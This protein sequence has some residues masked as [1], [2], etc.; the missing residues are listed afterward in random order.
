MDQGAGCVNTRLRLSI[1]GVV[2]GVGFRPFI[3]RLAH[4]M[5]LVG[6]VNNSPQGVLIE[7]EGHKSDLHNFINRLKTEK[8][9]LACIQS[10]E[11]HFL[12]PLGYTAFKI[13]ESDTRGR[14]DALILPDVATCADCRREIFDPQNRRYRYPFTNC[15]NCGPRFSIIEAL[16]YD[17]PNTTMKAFPMCEVCQAEYENPLDRRFHAQ[18]NACPV[19]GPHLQLWNAGGEVL[20]THKD[21]LRLAEE[22]IRQGKIVAVKGL[23]GFHLI[24]D[25]RNTCAVQRLRKA[26]ARDEKPFALFYPS[27]EMIAYDCVVSDAEAALLQSPEAPIVLLLRHRNI[28][29]STEVAPGHPYL[30]VMLPYTP[31]HHLL[32]ADLGFP[33]VATSGNLSDEPICTDEREALQRLAGIADLFLVHNRP[34]VRHVDDSIVRLMGGREMIL[35]RARG[36]A[37]LPI[38]VSM[39]NPQSKPSLAVGGHLKNTVALS[40]G[41]QVFLSQHIGDLETAEAFGAFQRVVSDF[42][43]LYDVQPE[44]IAH[45]LHPDYLSTQFARKQPLVQKGVQHHVAHVLACMAENE[46]DPPVLGVSWDGTGYGTD[47]TIWGGEFFVITARKS[48]QGTHLDWERVACIEPFPLPGGETAV[49]EPRRSAIGLLYHYFGDEVFGGW[50]R[51]LPSVQAFSAAELKII[52]SMLKQGLNC[53][54]TSSVGRLF[55]AMASLLDCCQVMN[56]EG[57]AAMLLEFLAFE[58]GVGE[59]WFED[60]QK[61]MQTKN[62]ALSLKP[63]LTYLIQ[64]IRSNTCRAKIAQLFHQM[65]TQIIVDQAQRHGLQKVVISGG[66]FQNKYLTETIIEQLN[67]HDFRVYWHQR[68]PPNDGGISLGQ[69]IAVQ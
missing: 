55:D 16:P 25:A 41:N 40:V 50:G 5:G 9:A 23:G 53:P 60:N 11:S 38:S 51:D 13:R 36:Y 24:V 58:E 61:I 48:L 14:K 15:T 7:V 20:A 6:W 31:L 22:A 45:D 29:I 52:H 17:R 37:P 54:M 27:V 57:Q 3:Y 67:Q 10:L 44:V 42:Q 33:V 64:H 18:P 43:R 8:P 59:V 62:Y 39:L 1:R 4:E 32:L 2:Q 19:C 49:K 56:Y 21:A 66:C 69:I 28:S 68:I 35:R 12:D 30:G 65:L 63:W 26:K 34:I 46:V 47:G